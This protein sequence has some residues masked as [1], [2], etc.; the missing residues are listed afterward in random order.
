MLKV[1]YEG[2]PANA[3]EVVAGQVRGTEDGIVVLIIDGGSHN[4]VRVN[5]P[6]DPDEKFLAVF[7]RSGGDS[8]CEPFSVNENYG[9]SSASDIRENFPIILDAEMTIGRAK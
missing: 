7:L 9:L 2:K 6:K 5:I 1:N 8:Y 3:A 4:E